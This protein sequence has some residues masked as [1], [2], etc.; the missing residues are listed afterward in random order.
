MKTGDLGFL[1]G[2]GYLHLTGRAK[3]LIIRGGV[4]ISPLEIDGVL[5]QRSEVIEACTVGVPDNMYGEEVVAYVVLRPGVVDR[6]RRHPAPLRRGAAGVQD[7]E[8]DRAERWIAEDRARQ[9]RPQG[10]GGAM[11]PRSNTG[12]KLQDEPN[13]W[14]GLALILVLI[15]VF[16][17]VI[18][19]AGLP[20]SPA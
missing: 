2:E 7:A 20:K 11:D 14:L 3:D 8:A 15:L 17:L 6:R 12:M 4:N 19:W 18:H 1:D 9:A 16:A 13:N 5:M 10:A